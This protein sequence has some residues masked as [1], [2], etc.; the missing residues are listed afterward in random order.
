MEARVWTIRIFYDQLPAM[1]LHDTIGNGK[2]QAGSL[3]F[4]LGG[5]I[6]DQ[7]SCPE[8]KCNNYAKMFHS[9]L[10]AFPVHFLHQPE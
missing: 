7:E 3:A 10:N 1:V 6:Q 4:G 8:S 9:R 2:S 5:K